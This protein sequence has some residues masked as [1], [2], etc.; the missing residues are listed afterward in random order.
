MNE[1]RPLGRKLRDQLIIVIG[2]DMGFRAKELRGLKPSMFHFDEGIII[3]PGHIQKEYPTGSSPSNATLE[4]DPY[5]LFGTEQLLKTYQDSEWYQNQDTDYL[6]PTRQSDQMTTE[7]IRNVVKRAAVEADVRPKRTDGEPSEP[8]EMHPHVLRHSLASYM[9]KDEKTRLVDVRN[10][11]R[12]RFTS[13]T[14]RIYEHF[15]KR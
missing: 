6:F 2:A 12:H 10:R 5:D 11:L 15:Q 8:T 3:I 14:E 4:I 9:L 1:G 13:T 7:T